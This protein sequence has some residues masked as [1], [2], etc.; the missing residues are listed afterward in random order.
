MTADNAH[1]LVV[2][3]NPDSQKLLEILLSNQGYNVTIVD[4]GEKALEAVL[5]GNFDLTFMDCQMPVLDGFSA[6]RKLRRHGVQMPIIALT[7]YGRNEELQKCLD[8]G[9]DDCLTKPFRQ[10]H[11]FDILDKWGLK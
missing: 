1:I 10:N 7:A 5:N 4:N 9:M 8:A 2:E 3:D 6:T 11:L